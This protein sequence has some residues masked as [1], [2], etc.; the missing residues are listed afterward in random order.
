M[1]TPVTLRGGSGVQAH[2]PGVTL[3]AW[4]RPTLLPRPLGSHRAGAGDSTARAVT[5][6]KVDGVGFKGL[7]EVAA[8][9][10]ESP[11]QRRNYRA[12]PTRACTP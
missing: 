8:G 4:Q 12:Q 9:G 2:R 11:G 10:L 1:S 5:A 6:V 3:R 7:R